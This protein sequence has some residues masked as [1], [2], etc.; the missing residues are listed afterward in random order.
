MRSETTNGSDFHDLGTVFHGTLSQTDTERITKP[1]ARKSARV[2]VT[3]FHPRRRS[4]DATGPSPRVSAGIPGDI[5][6][7]QFAATVAGGGTGESA[8]RRRGIVPTQSSEASG[9]RTVGSIERCT[10]SRPTDME[11]ESSFAERRTG[12]RRE[13]GPRHEGAR[14]EFLTTVLISEYSHRAGA[15]WASMSPAEQKG[16]II[17]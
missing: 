10:S 3:P 12:L 8:S 1:L 17:V 5:P 7:P 6:S 13:H 11:G 16:G 14:L 9:A 2:R 4:G 15:A